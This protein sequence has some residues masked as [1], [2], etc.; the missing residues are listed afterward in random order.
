[1]TSRDEINVAVVDM[2]ETATGKQIGL[3]EIP[4]EP[5]MPYAILYPMSTGPDEGSW[6]VPNEDR[7]FNFQVKCV[8]ADARQ[9]GWMS[10]KVCAVMTDRTGTDYTEPLIIT[11]AAVHWR[12]T[13]ALGAIVPSGENLYEANDLY[14]IRIGA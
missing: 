11:G 6:G 13:E 8:G 3:C 5:S 9:T 7:T 10:S 4:M 2:L 14:Q 1:M 12:A